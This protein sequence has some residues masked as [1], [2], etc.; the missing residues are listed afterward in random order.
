MGLLGTWC[1]AY[2]DTH[3][4]FA[5]TEIMQALIF[6]EVIFIWVMYYVGT[7]NLIDNYLIVEKSQIT[8]EK[9][10]KSFK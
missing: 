10:R 6:Y 5:V 7:F 9:N 3:F 1:S 4:L 8:I 2:W